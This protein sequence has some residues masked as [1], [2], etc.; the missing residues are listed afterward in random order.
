[1]KDII[2]DVRGLSCPQP[3]LETL[4]AINKFEE[5]TIIVL[6]DTTTSRDNVR[7]AAEKK[8]FKTEIE[9]SNG[10]EFRVKLSK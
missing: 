8:G 4:S 2:V 9:V 3:V 7:R 1:M 10:D 6:V 5:G